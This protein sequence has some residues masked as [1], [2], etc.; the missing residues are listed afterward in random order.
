[1]SEV[2]YYIDYSE[3]LYRVSVYDNT[4]I[5]HY[6]KQLGWVSCLY[7]GGFSMLE[8]FSQEITEV[9]ANTLVMLWELEK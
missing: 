4:N 6:N 1:M 8:T 9:E 5:E 3:E 7:L 2:I